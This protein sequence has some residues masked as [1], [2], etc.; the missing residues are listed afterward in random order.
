M[1]LCSSTDRK[2]LARVSN[3]GLFLIQVHGIFNFHLESIQ[4]QSLMLSPSTEQTA[5]SLTTFSW[6]KCRVNH[7]II[8]PVVLCSLAKRILLSFQMIIDLENSSDYTLI[9]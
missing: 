5:C 6:K 7:F 4:L 1:Q 8:E 9:R 2:A 3:Q